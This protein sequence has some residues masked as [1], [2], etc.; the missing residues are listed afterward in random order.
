MISALKNY[1]GNNTESRLVKF[2]CK[3]NVVIVMCAKFI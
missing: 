2:S 3:I 1:G